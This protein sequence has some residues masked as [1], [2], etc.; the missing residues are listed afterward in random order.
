M[1]AVKISGHSGF[2]LLEVLIAVFVLSIGLLG[3]A[4]L[5]LT[6]MRYAHNANLRYQAMQQVND[7]ADRLRANPQG[8]ASGAYNSISGSGSNPGC[9][10]SNCSPGQLAAYDAFI[11]N[12]NNALILPA[13][14]GTVSGNGT[15]TIFTITVTWTERAGRETAATVHNY[16]VNMI[17]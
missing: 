17:P 3:I 6:G 13:G 15:D 8:V 9:I 7:M 1:G 11:W 14:T 4:G 5:Q 10:S 2:S 12:T 16:T